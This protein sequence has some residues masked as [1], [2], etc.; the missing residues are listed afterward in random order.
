[1]YYMALVAMAFGDQTAAEK[2]LKKMNAH[3]EKGYPSLTALIILR[4]FFQ[5]KDIWREGMPEYDRYQTLLNGAPQ[6]KEVAKD[7]TAPKSITPQI[8]AAIAFYDVSV[9]LAPLKLEETSL[10]F[11]ALAMYLKADSVAFK[12]WA[13]ELLEMSGNHQAANRVYQ[14]IPHKNDVISRKMILNFLTIGQYSE[15]IPILRQMAQQNP[16]DPSIQMLLGESLFQTQDYSHALQTF[17]RATDLFQ[18]E[19]QTAG[20]GRALFM[21]A[22]IYDKMGNEEQVEKS[23][24]S[25]LRQIPNDPQTLNYLGYLWLDKRKNID[26]AFKMV[27]K[28]AELDPSDPAIMD[29]LALGYYLKK[30]Y[31]KALELAEKSTD[32]I[33]YSSVAYAH[34]GDIY[35]ALNRPKEAHYQY[36][37]ALDLTTDMTPELKAELEKKLNL[38][39]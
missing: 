31:Q 17:T 28:A 33:S 39:R 12:F 29:S 37:K 20:M 5:S 24:L 13:G 3:S 36:R 16:N 30:D 23:L 26:E 8:G 34:L 27:E 10:I 38:T 4:D 9:A 22:L 21:K 14:L 6:V 18:K 35:A 1:H 7:L 19:N 25:A 2:N 15:A 11:N 32:L